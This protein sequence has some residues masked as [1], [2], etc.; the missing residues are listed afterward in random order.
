MTARVNIDRQFTINLFIFEELRNFR[1]R[2]AQYTKL[3]H[4]ANVHLYV[5]YCPGNVASSELGK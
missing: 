3:T 2:K 4:S 1:C 5:L